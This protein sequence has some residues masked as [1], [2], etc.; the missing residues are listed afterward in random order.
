MDRMKAVSLRNSA[1][2]NDADAIELIAHA[3]AL[4]RLDLS[5]SSVSDAVW[6]NHFLFVCVACVCACFCVCACLCV[7]VRFKCIS[8]CIGAAL[9]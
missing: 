5:G 3:P 6:G 8:S 2:L 9:L 1:A 7:C 4:E